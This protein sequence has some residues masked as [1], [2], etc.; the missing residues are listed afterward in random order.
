[1]A[2]TAPPSVPPRPDEGPRDAARRPAAAGPDRAAVAESPP[3]ATPPAVEGP[4]FV[5]R[6]L[7]LPDQLRRWLRPDPAR[8]PRSWPRRYWAGLVILYAVLVAVAVGDAWVLTC[9]FDG[10]PST[11]D[12]RALRPSEGGR[13]LDRRGTLVGRVRSV[14]RV[15]VPLAQVPL[16]V[17]QAFVSTE[18]RRFYDH[19]GV[20]W[21]GAARAMFVNV[22]AGGVREGFSTIT[23]QVVR[24]TFAVQRQGERSVA[25][26]LL[27]LRLSRLIEGTLTKDQILELY[28][29]V[30]YLGNGV[31]GV[32]AASRDLFGHGVR[33]V[34]LPQGAVLAALP[35]GPSAY[36]P[37]AHPQRAR[38]RRDLVLTLMAREGY[39]S[40]ERARRAQGER[41]A[42]EEDEW[43]PDAANDS[44]ALDAVRQFVDSLREAEG[45]QSVDLLVETTLDL[46]AQRAAERAV[47]RRAAAIGA[48]AQGAM[49]ALDPRTGD[50][51][52]IVGGRAYG[53]RY[54]RGTFNRALKARRQP[55]SAFKPF[56]YAAALAG[57]MTPASG[58]D[59]EPIDVPLGNGRVWSPGNYEG[60]YLGHTTLRTALAK[61]ANGATVRVGQRVGPARV[62]E[63][64]SR[65]GITSPLQPVPSIVLGAVEVTPIELVTAYAPFANGGFRV[66]PRL[67]TRV[68]AQ[69]GSVLWTNEPRRRPVMD[70]RDAF[71]LTSMLRSV[72]L[73]GTGRAVTDAGVRDPVAGKT[74]TTNS[75]ADAWFV[76]YTPT[77]V[78]GFWFGYDDPRPMGRNATGGK[79]AAPAW[80]DF[81]V[82]GW[83][84]HAGDWAPP[85]GLVRRR[86]D[87]Y[88]GHLSN[89]WC[90]AT[91]DE[92]FKQG[93]EPTT[94]CAEH[95]EPYEPPPEPVVETPET[96]GR[97]A[98]DRR[99]GAQGRQEGRRLVQAASSSSDVA[100][101]GGRARRP[102]NASR[103]R[104]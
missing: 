18:D 1:M 94:V 19:R 48:G 7:A 25:R 40:A 89:E 72:V 4:T 12:I 81:Y 91:R 88:N 15:N 74:G 42:V 97:A 36:T 104:R 49:V 95:D 69:D 100:V 54:T 28:L 90:P 38:R 101:A 85:A 45:I 31:Y 63:V 33:Q 59:D 83:R 37:R 62:I 93:G 23:M 57:G 77:L 39:I 99:R 103:A 44:Y 47:A 66:A 35:K 76:G 71:V 92:W 30:I 24:N 82:A 9:G 8:P 13:I 80:A 5:A 26:K 50:V 78:A 79:L 102:G 84:E 87:A 73:E 67:V 32:E 34:T 64:A 21:R 53:E 60:S 20:D 10:C 46:T 27:E 58:V 3:R 11:G 6:L 68:K 96:A 52:A 56:V 41:L 29:N 51:R 98:R 22:R 2:S 70:A 75:G 16:H 14:R 55:G 17:R 65:A 61:S 43:R 86:I